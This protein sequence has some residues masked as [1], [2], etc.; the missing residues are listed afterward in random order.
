[1]KYTPSIPPIAEAPDNSALRE[2]QRTQAIRAVRERTFP[3]QKTVHYML[4]ESNS[5]QPLKSENGE[6]R[7]GQEQRDHCRRITPADPLLETRSGVER[8]KRNRRRDDITTS[9]D[10]E[11]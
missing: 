4:P 7:L 8:R 5:E 9:V 1:M 6:Q 3:A 10:E 2:I 11:A